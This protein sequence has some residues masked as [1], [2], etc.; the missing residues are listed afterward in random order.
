VIVACAALA[1]A[2]CN[3]TTPPAP[4][5]VQAVSKTKGTVYR[6]GVQPFGTARALWRRYDPIVDAVNGR[7]VGMT[8][9]FESA[10]TPEKYEQKLTA[11]ELDLAL[12]EP[13][14]VLNAERLGYHVFVQTGRED[15]IRGVI[16]VHRSAAIRKVRDLRRR[17]VALTTPGELASTMMVNMWLRE[18][19][20]NLDRQ[21]RVIYVGSDANALHT[22][23]QR[24]ADAAAVSWDAWLE[25]AAANPEA[26]AGLEPKWKT[27]T[28]SGP[29]LM[30]QQRVP[31]QDAA[32]LAAAFA[33]LAG[34]TAG[35]AA[36]ATAGLKRFVP[37]GSAPYDDVWEF[38]GEYAKVFRHPPGLGGRP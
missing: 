13:H 5:G 1:A 36:L 17:V 26:A 18:A 9:Q 37:A 21:A 38:V 32:L 11:G 3:R 28:L 27:D 8:L 31:A 25:F 22:V 29:A 33:G 4:T 6:F 20:F 34:T 30:V 2:A 35:R 7:L 19:S 14:V 23:Y 12:V 10:L 24:G 15:R 16:V